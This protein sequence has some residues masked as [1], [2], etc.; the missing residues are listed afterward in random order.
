MLYEHPILFSRDMVRAIL[1]GE[2]T[3]TR[4]IVRFPSVMSVKEWRE[5]V[6]ILTHLQSE[7]VYPAFDGGYNFYGKKISFVHV[8][9]PYGNVRE[10]LWVREAF[11]EGPNGK[12][13][14][15]ANQ[16]DDFGSDVIDFDTG[17]TV[18]LIWRPSIHMPRSACR[19]VL[20]IIGIRVERLQDITEQDARAEGI[21]PHVAD[22]KEAYKDLWNKINFDRGYGWHL[23]P[24]VWVIEF[25][26]ATA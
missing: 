17:E 5:S 7:F 19:I 20:E 22:P 2:K 21:D 23:N 14:Y 25:K 10:F 24:W 26:K 18:P 1:I 11:A 16:T 8:K 9:C 12:Y 3:Q 6:N 4:R 13:I 15:K